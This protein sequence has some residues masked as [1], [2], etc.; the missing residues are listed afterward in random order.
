MY[1]PASRQRNHAQRVGE[2]GQLEWALDLL[3]REQRLTSPLCFLPLSARLLRASCS[4]GS[5]YSMPL[6]LTYNLALPF[7]LGASLFLITFGV[8]SELRSALVASTC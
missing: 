1:S 8:C 7:S 5:R 2:A 4:S 6:R 3:R